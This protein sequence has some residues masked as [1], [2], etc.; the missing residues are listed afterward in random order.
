MDRRN[1]GQKAFVAVT[2]FSLRWFTSAMAEVLYDKLY[3]FAEN[4]NYMLTHPNMSFALYVGV[5]VFYLALELLFTVVSIWC[6]LKNYVYKHAQMSKKELLVLVTPSFMGVVGYRIIWYYR[7]FYI[8]ES[9]K[10]SDIYDILSLFYCAVAIITIVV[11]IVLYQSIKAGQEEKL[12]NELL[13]AQISSI[14]QHIEQVENLYQDIRGIRH[15]MTN[16]LITLERLYA[17]KKTE[18]AIAY[19]TELKAVLSEAAGRINSGNP[20]TDVILQEMQN[21]AEKQEI[22]FDIDFHYPAGSI[23]NV[24]DISVILNNALQNALENTSESEAPYI[25]ILSYRR[26]NAYMIEIS[27]SFTGTLQWNPESGLPV[28]SKRET[29]GHAPGSDHGYGHNHSYGQGNRYSHSHGYG[30]ANIRRVAEKYAG[31]V[32]IDLRDGM[33]CLSILLMME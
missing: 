33:F 23:V 21:K 22:R 30:L 6:I 28:T 2:F 29:D 5:C 9:Q 4:T 10:N 20:V 27:N 24:F 13:A 1:Y 25:S 3:S 19:S 8:A 11:V 15:D 16:H 32:A 31:D 26:N 17:G 14:R 12:Q 18:E 7:Y